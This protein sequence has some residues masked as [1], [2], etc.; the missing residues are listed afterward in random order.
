[1]ERRYN[2]ILATE[3]SNRD[4]A[5]QM[6]AID[7]TT[8]RI[9]ACPGVWTRNRWT[10][11]YEADLATLYKDGLYTGIVRYK[12]FENEEE[13]LYAY[14]RL[15]RS[16]KDTRAFDGWTERRLTITPF[17]ARNAHPRTI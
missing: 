12:I 2:A 1:M 9:L 17:T 15:S 13:R 16:I 5:I 10:E 4:H 8:G 11:K 3:L 6:A 7:P 14:S